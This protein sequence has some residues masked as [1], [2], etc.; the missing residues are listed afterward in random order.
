[1]QMLPMLETGGAGMDAAAGVVDESDNEAVELAL[2][3]AATNVVEGQG[4]RFG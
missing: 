2:R 4:R 3:R 1:M